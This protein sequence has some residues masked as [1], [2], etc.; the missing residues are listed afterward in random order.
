MF[1]VSCDGSVPDSTDFENSIRKAIS[2]GSDSDT[3][4]SIAGAIAHAFYWDIPDWMTND[5]LGVPHNCFAVQ[6]KKPAEIEVGGDLI[7][8]GLFRTSGGRLN[9]G[10]MCLI[11][12]CLLGGKLTRC[13]RKRDISFS[14]IRP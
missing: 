5:C 9:T 8:A 2:L 6:T 4:A 10:G 13:D 1:D 3:I 7:F 12:A 11:A 14:A